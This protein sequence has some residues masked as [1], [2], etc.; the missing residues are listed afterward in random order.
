VYFGGEG[1]QIEYQLP[2]NN[3]HI[4]KPQLL[5]WDSS[6]SKRDA[7]KLFLEMLIR[8]DYDVDEETREE[9]GIEPQGGVSG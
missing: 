4:E 6:M 7:E 1:P 3:D 8:H 2:E 5:D 9:Y